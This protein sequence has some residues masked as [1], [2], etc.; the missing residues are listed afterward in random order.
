MVLNTPPGEVFNTAM[1][2]RYFN[3]EGKLT[4]YDEKNGLI[5]DVTF[6]P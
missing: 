4:V 3:I 1:G 2:D 5:A 6:N